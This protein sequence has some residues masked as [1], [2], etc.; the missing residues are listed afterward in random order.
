MS[1]QQAIAEMTAVGLQKAAFFLTEVYE[2]CAPEK[3]SKRLG[4]RSSE[5]GYKAR[6]A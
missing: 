4:L 2:K 1:L 5:F 3:L 6:V